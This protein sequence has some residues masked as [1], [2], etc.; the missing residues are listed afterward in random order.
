MLTRRQW[1]AMRRHVRREAPLETCGLL[2]GKEARVEAV[3]PA[4]NAA[5]S[6]VR[7]RMEPREQWHAFRWIED[8][9]LELL[10]VYHSHP[11][12]PH[13]PSPTD[14]E[15]ALYPVVHV[16]WALR[17]GKWQARGYWIESRQVSEVTLEVV[18]LEQ[19][20]PH[21]RVTNCAQD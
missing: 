3:L 1:N 14:V 15:E 11:A 4:R 21:I 9:G 18:N 2:A 6:P 8:Q 17:A 12:G 13:Q 10:G 5:Q 16:I 7:F 20:C 19:P